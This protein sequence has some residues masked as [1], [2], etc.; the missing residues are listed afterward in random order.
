MGLMSCSIFAAAGW[1]S[2]EQGLNLTTQFHLLS[3]SRHP[4]YLAGKYHVIV[5][6]SDNNRLFSIR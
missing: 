2:L 4:D 3:D 5:N 6:F 1:C